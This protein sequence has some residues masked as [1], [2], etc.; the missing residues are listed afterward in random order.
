MTADPTDI[1]MVANGSLAEVEAWGVALRDAGIECQV[2]G[3]HLAAGLGTALPGSAELWVHKWD[4]VAA[5]DILSGHDPAPK[6]GHPV[7]D[8]KP[9]RT[10]EL[11]HGGPHHSR[12]PRGH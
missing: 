5:T 12:R 2:V 9:D 7:S 4:A 8:A 6:H 10:R 3:D 11:P 1:V